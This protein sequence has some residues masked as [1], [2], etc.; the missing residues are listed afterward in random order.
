[1][2]SARLIIEA[3]M[4][5]IQI[6]GAQISMKHPNFVVNHGNAKFEDVI[7][8]VTEVKKAVKEKSGVD[9]HEEI[10]IVK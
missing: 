3:G 6:G 10:I 5:G 7:N 9:L 2:F 4:Q 1:M 8:L